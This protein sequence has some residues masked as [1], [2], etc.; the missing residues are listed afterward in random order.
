MHSERLFGQDHSDCAVHT[1]FISEDRQLE[2]CVAGRMECSGFVV[3]L[4]C[5]EEDLSGLGH[6]AADNDDV[7]I[8]HAGDVCDR[9]AQHL[10]DDVDDGE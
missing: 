7:G 2:V 3:L 10:A 1:G 9:L 6:A 4:Y 8:Y 5:V